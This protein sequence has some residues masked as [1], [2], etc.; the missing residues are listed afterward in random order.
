MYLS[1]SNTLYKD[2]VQVIF[3][4]LQSE[5]HIRLHEHIAKRSQ[6]NMALT[7]QVW[8]LAC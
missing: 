8:Y 4:M 3:N 6:L 7:A 2:Y 5:L 1:H